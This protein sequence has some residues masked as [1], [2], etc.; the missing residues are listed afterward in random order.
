[1]H[2]RGVRLAALVAAVILLFALLSAPRF[3]PRAEAG[4]RASVTLVLAAT[5]QGPGAQAC[6]SVYTNNETRGWLNVAN[7]TNTALTAPVA[8]S[9]TTVEA[10][11]LEPGTGSI[12]HVVFNSTT[13]VATWDI[14]SLD[15][16]NIKSGT[17]PNVKVYK[18]P[19]PVP[20]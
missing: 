1:M 11:G 16:G 18:A 20:Q 19:A 2:I 6:A 14:T 4:W 3:V 15:N 9:T 5:A 17:I 12:V 10:S 13:K 8:T 7:T